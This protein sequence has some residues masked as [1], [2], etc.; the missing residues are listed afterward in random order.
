MNQKEILKCLKVIEQLEKIDNIKVIK[1][2]VDIIEEFAYIDFE[3]E[4]KKKSLIVGY[5]EQVKEYVFKLR[6]EDLN[7]LLGG[8]VKKIKIEMIH[9]LENHIAINGIY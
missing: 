1:K 4:N 8:F 6:D 7:K 5:N 2:G 9:S 3:F